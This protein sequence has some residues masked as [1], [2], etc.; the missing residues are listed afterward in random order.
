MQRRGS[1]E[2]RQRS[3]GVGEMQRR[4]A[5]EERNGTEDGGSGR[6]LQP[7]LPTVPPPATAERPRLSPVEAVL[8]DLP[9]RAA[10]PSLA[11]AE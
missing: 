11:M 9:S 10:V 5:I 3:G 2:E 4:G 8:L 7:S 6:A 1:I